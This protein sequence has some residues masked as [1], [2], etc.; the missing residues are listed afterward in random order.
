VDETKWLNLKR[1]WS[2]TLDGLT[3]FAD[4][5]FVRL[6]EMEVDT[7]VIPFETAQGITF[8]DFIGDG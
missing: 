2:Q 6:G 7:D 4:Y 3:R 8:A 5:H 1:D